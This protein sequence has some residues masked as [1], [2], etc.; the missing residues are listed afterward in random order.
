M[1][2]TTALV[3]LGTDLD[4]DSSTAQGE[5]VTRSVVPLHS[6]RGSYENDKDFFVE[7]DGL[8]FAGTH[9]IID[10]WGCERIGEIDHIDAA[11]RESVEAAGATLLHIHLHHFTPNDGVSGVAVLAESHISVHTW[12]EC[13]YAAFDV[14]MC[15][16]ARPN[17]AIE[18]LKRYFRPDRVEVSE[19]LRGRD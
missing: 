8:R 19:H 16:D 11:M 1:H 18:V 5:D 3:Q 7:R 15:G 17:A 6:D 13:G 4:R 10:L 9:L 12:P 2:K 14:F